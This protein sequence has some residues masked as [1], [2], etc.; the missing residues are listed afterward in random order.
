M[1]A[2]E[3]FFF[4]RQRHSK[5]CFGSQPPGWCTRL[6]ASHGES[7]MPTILVHQITPQKMNH[8]PLK[9][10][11]SKGK[12]RLPTIEGLLVFAAIYDFWHL[13]TSFDTPDV[14]DS[15]WIA[16]NTLPFFYRSSMSSLLVPQFF[17]KNFEIYQA[18]CLSTADCFPFWV[19]TSRRSRS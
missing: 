11:R 3:G 16:K 9:R 8:F 1:F 15:S 12:D 13:L 7:Q 2:I 6:T 10:D 18:R 14:T 4:R 19:S 5:L 17:R